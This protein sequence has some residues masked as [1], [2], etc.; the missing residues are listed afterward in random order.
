EYEVTGTSGLVD[1]TI[2]NES[3]GTEQ[4]SNVTTPWKKSY[5]MK[6]GHVY[7]SA[8]NQRE[9]GTVNVKVYVDGKV[10]KESSSEGAYVIASVS[11]WV[12]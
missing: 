8:Q 5:Y 7:I 9:R 4:F 1:I 10:L 11:D 6:S 3:G 2:S 12:Y